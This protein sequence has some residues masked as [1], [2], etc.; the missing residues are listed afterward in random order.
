MNLP[1][2]I[3]A[4]YINLAKAKT[5]Q[6]WW[7]TLI[8]AALAGAFI[9]L[10]AAVATVAGSGFTGAQAS[11]I[12]A[13]VFPLG[14]ILVVICGAELFTGNCLLIAPLLQRE[15]KVKGVLK[16]LGL[17][18]LGNLLGA[19]LIALLV[20]GGKAYT[21][22]AALSAVSAAA[23]KCNLNFG[24]GVLRG[25]LCNI[26]VCLAVWGA[27]ASKN[28]VGKILFVYMPVFAFVACGFEH[29][30]ANMFYLSAGLLA[31]PV[32]GLTADGLNIGYSL[33]NGLLAPT[34]GNIIGGALIGIAY[35]AVY[36]KV[37][38]QQEG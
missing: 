14:L 17:V 21:D 34:I 15:V 19:V 18:Y 33:L 26:L 23:A 30:V 8:L 20:V 32:Y 36:L 25:I 22:A 3:A 16:N 9:A 13:A 24:Y 37:K 11:L 6:V 4:N 35:W 31:Q 5:A 12:K 38:K 29:S 10:G 1:V 7:K 2:E 27:M 28:A